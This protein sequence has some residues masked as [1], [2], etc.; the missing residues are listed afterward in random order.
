MWDN[1][2][3]GVTCFLGKS[4]SAGWHTP[5]PPLSYTHATCCSNWAQWLWDSPG[6]LRTVLF[7]KHSPFPLSTLR[8]EGPWLVCHLVTSHAA[9]GLSSLAPGTCAGALASPQGPGSVLQPGR[10]GP[11]GWCEWWLVGSVPRDA[12]P[13]FRRKRWYVKCAPRQ[14]SEERAGSGDGILRPA[15]SVFGEQPSGADFKPYFKKH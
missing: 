15:G 13:A 8:S 5:V 1:T 4:Y 14:H 9:C 6:T 3:L 10:A 12:V 2:S 7:S 11:A